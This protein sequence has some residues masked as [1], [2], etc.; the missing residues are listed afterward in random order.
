MILDAGVLISVDRGDESARAFL[1]AVAR[2]G[3]Q[4]HTSHPVVAQVWRDGSRQA[5]LAAF[6]KT[7]TVHP[8]DDGPSVGRLLALSRASD[9]VDGHLVHLALR[10]RDDILAG[11]PDDLSKLVAVLG[12]SGPRIHSWP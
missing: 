5:R 6:L 9:V 1:T 10:L 4:L 12:P 8:L 11:D 3:T 2:S 7:V